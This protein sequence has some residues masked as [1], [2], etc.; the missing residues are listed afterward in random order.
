MN[1]LL[2][3]LFDPVDIPFQ[4]RAAIIRKAIEERQKLFDKFAPESLD[5]YEERQLEIVK[6]EQRQIADELI[7]GNVSKRRADQMGKRL[8]ELA[9]IN[10]KVGEKIKRNRQKLARYNELSQPYDTTI[11]KGL[12]YLSNLLILSALVMVLSICVL[13]IMA[14]YYY[15]VVTRIGLHISMDFY[16]VVCQL[17]VALAVAAYFSGRSSKVKSS[18]QSLS[19]R[20][21]HDID[22]FLFIV[23]GEAACLTAIALN[24][25]NTF[26]FFIAIMSLVVLTVT[27]GRAALYP[28]Q[29]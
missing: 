13:I 8:D 16:Q 24:F 21:R 5:S 11:N 1:K 3:Y 28:D 18:D 29:R 19:E 20:L 7:R 26:L 15:D 17:I 23:L 10:N 14:T 4:K 27:V 9:A 25:T 2:K 6:Q 12:A 22:T